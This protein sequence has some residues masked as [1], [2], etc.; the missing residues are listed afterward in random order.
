MIENVFKNINMNTNNCQH[1]HQQHEYSSTN[2]Q[3]MNIYFIINKKIYHG[4]WSYVKNCY[5]V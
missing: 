1:N 5:R 4:C 3:L 2:M